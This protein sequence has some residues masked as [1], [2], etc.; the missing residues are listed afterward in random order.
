MV[1]VSDW[2]A[3]QVAVL[4]FFIYQSS[5]MDCEYLSFRSMYWTYPCQ[6]PV[7]LY[8]KMVNKLLTSYISI[9]NNLLLQKKEIN[10]H[11]HHGNSQCLPATLFLRPRP[12]RYVNL[13]NILMVAGRL[14]C[15]FRSSE[16]RGPLLWNK[17]GRGPPMVS[18]PESIQDI[19]YCGSFLRI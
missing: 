6:H 18:S 15:W 5:I 19:F 4:V 13:A 7:I 12:S 11:R 14:L 1:L 16:P 17:S 3:L 8:P 2:I 9:E 10:K